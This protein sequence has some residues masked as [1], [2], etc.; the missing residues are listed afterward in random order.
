MMVRK[1]GCCLG[2][3]GVRA[4]DG[5][6]PDTKPGAKQLGARLSCINGTPPTSAGT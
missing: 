3:L 4:R 5:A 1:T 6:V 2:L